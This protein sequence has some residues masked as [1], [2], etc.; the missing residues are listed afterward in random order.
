MSSAR[1]RVLFVSKPVVPPFRDG[2]KCLVRDVSLHLT[3]YAP[4]VM[5]TD[6]RP[7]LSASAEGEHAVELL[8]V[9]RSA[10]SYAPALTANAR[11]AAYLVL[12]SRAELWHFVFAPN[13]KS[14]AVG[15]VA[16]AIRRVPVV[17]TVASAPRRFVPD[18]FFGDVVV[19]QSRATEAAIRDAFDAA[20]RPAPRLRIV[21]P[22]LGP[23]T[24][25]TAAEV[26]TTIA[27]LD[28]PDGA[29][30]FVYPGDLEVSTAADT[31]ARAA[32]LIER[33]LPHAVVVF[34][35]RQKTP[36]AA[37]VEE[38]LRA[39][40]DGHRVRFVRET[41]L[42]ALYARTTA[43]LFPVDDLWGKVDLPIAVLEAMRLGVPV[44]A[45]DVGPL[46]DLEGVVRVA[47]G[48][49]DGL[50]AGAVKLVTDNAH[51]ARMIDEAR[52]YVDARHDAAVVA[53]AYETVYDEL[54]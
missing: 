33:A 36:A 15:R 50:A 28:V 4:A 6:D 46:L 30:L 9:Y 42:L 26:R 53:R 16:R 19:A 49:A 21:P 10:G 1:P 12:R 20:S 25:R 44:I 11:A 48:D 13:P 43:V 29:P 32:P 37:R 7:P 39:R 40:L 2:T 41:D 51:R 8:P 17:Q 38:E 31:V 45:A 22:P 35:C 14:T 27:P 5:S 24:A 3:R 18:V 47:P 54:L 52:R 34:A 23:L